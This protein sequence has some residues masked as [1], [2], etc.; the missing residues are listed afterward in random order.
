[1]TEKLF[2]RTLR[3]NQPTPA[4]SGCQLL[5]KEW[6]LNSVKLLTGSQKKGLEVEVSY[7]LSLDLVMQTFLVPFSRF[8]ERTGTKYR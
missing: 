8:Y 4:E 3:I 2:T 6:A 5:E 7:I 1:M